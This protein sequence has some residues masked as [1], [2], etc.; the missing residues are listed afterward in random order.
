ML[1]YPEFTLQQYNQQ[2]N[3]TP[4]NR[5]THVQ[6]APKRKYEYYQ[7]IAESHVLIRKQRMT[8]RTI[9]L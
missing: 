6:L 8:N 4:V 3:G 7:G 5:S 9:S 2:G 1:T